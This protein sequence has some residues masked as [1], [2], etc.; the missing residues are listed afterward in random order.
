MQKTVLVAGSHGGIGKALVD[1]FS[2]KGCEV[3]TI[4]RRQSNDSPNH[5]CVDMSDPQ[6]IDVIREWIKPHMPEVMGIVNCAGVLHSD[7]YKP[8]KNLGQVTDE[9]LEKSMMG[10]V[11]PHLHLAQA[12][13]PLLTSQSCLKWISL[14]AK[15]GSIEDNNLGGW[16]SY[17]MTKAALNMLIKTLSIEWQRRA[18]NCVVVAMHPGTTPSSL[19]DPFT[20][21][22]PKE[23]LYTPSVTANR[24]L[25]QFET[26]DASHSG[27]LFHHDGS[28]IPW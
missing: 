9:W 2:S 25:T 24:I 8:E 16:Y 27:H 20:T 6:N 21:N 7:H 12:V 11:L 26:M 5:L 28:V 3:I 14:S 15:V 13:G 1:A 18:K 23:K 17:R 10:N 22:W 4:S 19:S